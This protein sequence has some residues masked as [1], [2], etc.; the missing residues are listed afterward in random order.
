MAA[1]FHILTS[2]ICKF[3]FSHIFASF[4]VIVLGILMDI[5]V[6]HCG[7]SLHFPNN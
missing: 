7:F 5:V 2:N 1:S 4:D 3:Q 6:A